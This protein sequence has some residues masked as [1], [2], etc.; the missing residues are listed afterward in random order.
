MKNP[1]IQK[2]L[3]TFNETKISLNEKIKQSIQNNSSH[4]QPPQSPYLILNNKK[5]IFKKFSLRLDSVI[6]TIRLLSKTINI[7]N[8]NVNQTLY[9]QKQNQDKNHNGNQKKSFSVN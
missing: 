8:S 6:K 5:K 7:F 2:K 1:L 4:H 3:S 9:S